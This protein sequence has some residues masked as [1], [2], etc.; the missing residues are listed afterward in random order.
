[1]ATRKKAPA[2]EAEPVKVPKPIAPNR[3]PVP[4]KSQAEVDALLS[5]VARAREQF[6]DAGRSQAD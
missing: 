5:D 6:P 2:P 4:R 1:M 3:G